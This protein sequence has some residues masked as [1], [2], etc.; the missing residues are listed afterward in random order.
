[1]RFRAALAIYK[2]N[3]PLFEKSSGATT[4][5]NI[6]VTIQKEHEANF[7]ENA[8]EELADELYNDLE[9]ELARARTA[10]EGKKA[11]SAARS[12][13]ALSRAACSEGEPAQTSGPPA[14]RSAHTSEN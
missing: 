14:I 2:S 7:E 6:F 9:D 5:R 8:K 3:K 1:V 11:S 13:L 10:P 4:A 12:R